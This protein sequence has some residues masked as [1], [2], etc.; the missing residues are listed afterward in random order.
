MICEACSTAN[1]HDA[2]FCLIQA[3]GLRRMDLE[4]LAAQ[5]RSLRAVGDDDGARATGADFD[6]RSRSI[7]TRI[8]DASLRSA[9]E[10]SLAGR[11]GESVR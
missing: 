9:F 8:D 10:A 2:A 11:L 3:N 6:E 7:L 4:L 5:I 1:P